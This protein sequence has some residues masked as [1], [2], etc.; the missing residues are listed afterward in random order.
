MGPGQA[1]C[2]SMRKFATTRCSPIIDGIGLSCTIR[3]TKVDQLMEPSRLEM[4]VQEGEQGLVGGIQAASPG[5][6]RSQVSQ[7]NGRQHRGHHEPQAVHIQG[8]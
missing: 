2:G 6:E 4:P 5:V 7:G 1:R 3:T 8:L